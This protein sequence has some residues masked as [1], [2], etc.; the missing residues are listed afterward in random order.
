MRA[1]RWAGA[2]SRA[3]APACDRSP[4]AIRIEETPSGISWS[5]WDPGFGERDAGPEPSCAGLPGYFAGTRAHVRDTREHE[6]KVGQ[7]V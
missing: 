7:A 2:T 4:D 5:D 6:E 1:Y 3:I